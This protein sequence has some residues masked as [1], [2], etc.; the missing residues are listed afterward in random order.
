MSVAHDRR[1]RTRARRW[2]TNGALRSA[3]GDGG[4]R[5]DDGRMANGALEPGGA[6][7]Q[8][9]RFACCIAVIRVRRSAASLG[10][11][12]K[13]GGGNGGGGQ[14]TRGRPVGSDRSNRRQ[15]GGKPASTPRAVPL[16]SSS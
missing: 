6:G 1:D 15:T 16:Q 9:R 2:A 11:I 7:R 4:R 3:N 10:A 13:K 14:R 12:R 8:R 5:T